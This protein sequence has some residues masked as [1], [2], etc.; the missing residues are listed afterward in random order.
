MVYYKAFFQPAF[1]PLISGPVAKHCHRAEFHLDLS[2]SAVLQRL[3]QEKNSRTANAKYIMPNT[4]N[5]YKCV[6]CFIEYQYVTCS[7]FVTGQSAC[8]HMD[9]YTYK[10]MEYAPLPFVQLP[11]AAQCGPI[12]AVAHCAV[13]VSPLDSL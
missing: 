2:A 6:C 8:T 7:Q 13:A 12:R 4:Y 3:A 1:L 11:T 9:L 5:T 10:P